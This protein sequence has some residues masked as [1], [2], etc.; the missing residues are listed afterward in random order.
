[1]SAFSFCSVSIRDPDTLIQ[2]PIILGLDHFDDQRS[3]SPTADIAATGF[4]ACMVQVIGSVARSGQI[5]RPHQ[6]I[7]NAGGHDG[8]RVLLPFQSINSIISDM[9]SAHELHERD[10]LPAVGMAGEYQIGCCFR[11]SGMIIRRMVGHDGV[12]ILVQLLCQIRDFGSTA[13]EIRF[14]GSIA[15]PEK[16]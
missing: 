13:A 15:M 6:R 11:F 1:M 9:E 14:Y 3:D 12:C 5:C 16:I 8:I 4:F 2:P 7:G 10:H